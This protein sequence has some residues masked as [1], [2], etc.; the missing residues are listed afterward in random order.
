LNKCL[1]SDGWWNM[2]INWVI[3][4]DL[5]DEIWNVIFNDTFSVHRINTQVFPI[6]PC[7]RMVLIQTLLY[8]PSLNSVF[9]PSFSS[10][11]SLL[12]NFIHVLILLLL[13]ITKH[14]RDLKMWDVRRFRDGIWWK[15]NRFACIEMLLRPNWALVDIHKLFRCE[16]IFGEKYFIIFVLW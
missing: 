10:I 13:K 11:P 15:S 1:V 7:W 8:I 12:S 2:L 4:L 14:S 16:C 5:S 6:I 3:S 9:L